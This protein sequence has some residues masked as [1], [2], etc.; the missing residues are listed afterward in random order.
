V[1]SSI[2]LRHL[3]YFLAVME[4]QHFGRAAERLYMAQPPLSQA[5]SKLEEELG[6]DLLL[7]TSRGVVPTGVQT[8]RARCSASRAPCATSSA[9]LARPDD[10][11]RVSLAA[12]RYWTFRA[13]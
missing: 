1:T 10:T 4:E 8:R 5:I 11:P 13:A 2:Q 3:R 12:R 9:P 6:V 7:R